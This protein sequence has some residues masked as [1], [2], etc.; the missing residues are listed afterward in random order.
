MK[1]Y[2]F[3]LNRNI[4]L[5]VHAVFS[6]LPL[7]QIR[8]KGERR[9]KRKGK[10]REKGEEKGRKGEGEGEKTVVKINF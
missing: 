5:F 1:K 4:L 3:F 6:S 2:L 8:E 7:C 10:K 9:E